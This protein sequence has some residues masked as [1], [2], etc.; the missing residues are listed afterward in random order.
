MPVVTIPQ[1]S[2]TKKPL[3]RGIKTSAPD[4]IS[5]MLAQNYT[6]EQDGKVVVATM[7]SSQFGLTETQDICEDLR[8]HMRND[9]AQFFVLDLASIE[10]IDS[11]CV[12]GLVEFLQDLEHVRGRIVL[13]NC[14]PNVEF[15]FKVT[16]L[17]N[18][19]RIFDDVQDAIEEFDS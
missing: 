18:V 12:G 19:F 13:A 14:Q 15:L 4:D 2:H 10:F 7:N 17:D 1:N 11:A 6:I 3:R 9:G 5:Y 16:R 8:D